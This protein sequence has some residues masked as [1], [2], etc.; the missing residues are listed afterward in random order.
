M[1]TSN[2][3]PH[4]S[5]DIL[6][7][8]AVLGL[9][10]VTG[11][12]FMQTARADTVV[13]VVELKTETN[14]ETSRL[15]AGTTVAGRSSQ[16]GFKRTGEVARVY[17]DL[18]DQVAV[19]E[20]IAELDNTAL[21]VVLQQSRAA[22]DVAA[23]NLKSQVAERQLAKNTATRIARLHTDGHASK[24]EFDEV[25]L[26]LQAR[27]A[28]VALARAELK[29]AEAAM[30]SAQ[31]ALDESQL[32]APF[33]GV[34]QAR[35]VDEG[36]QLGMAQAVVELIDTAR[37]E[38][39]VAV[40]VD[41]SVSL[42]PESVHQLVWAGSAYPASLN[43]VLPKVDPVTRTQTAVFNIEAQGIPVGGLIKLEVAEKVEADGYWLPLSSLTQAD[44][45]LW[46]VYVVN[47]QNE[48]ERRLV[49]VV[50]TEA[51]RV[52]ARGTLSSGDMLVASGAQRVVP[53]QT[54][55]PVPT[56]QAQNAY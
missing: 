47:G 50:Y 38:A 7:A 34:V 20:L 2:M 16:L 36:A 17:F 19:G 22:K 11:P 37:V 39:H 6:K 25:K 29:R 18:G 41:L 5:S 13:P 53:G 51:E 3:I 10:F 14:F 44:R 23:A 52:F 24:Q 1:S 12:G 35:Y 40:P 26:G 56:M 31:V 43:S 49:D 21:K 46:A 55:T 30:Q 8:F 45:G 28:Q 4:L 27:D 54:V 9:L 42:V 48:I 32:F 33:A 15:L